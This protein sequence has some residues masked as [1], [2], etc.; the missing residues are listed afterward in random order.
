M[1]RRLY[2]DRLNQFDDVLA[3]HLTHSFGLIVD[4]QVLLNHCSFNLCKEI[5]HARCGFPDPHIHFDP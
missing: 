5:L 2:V 1:N 3:Q 4:F